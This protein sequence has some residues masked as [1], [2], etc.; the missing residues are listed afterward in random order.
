MRSITLALSILA[1]LA[2]ALPAT[3][4]P[5]LN[6]PC[7]NPNDLPVVTTADGVTTDVDTPIGLPLLDVQTVSGGSYLVDLAGVE[8][9][10][11]KTV[12]VTLSWT[13]GILDDLTDYDM[14]VNGVTYNASDTRETATLSMGHCKTIN[15]EEIYDVHRDPGRQL[16]PGPGHLLLPLLGRV[17]PGTGLTT[18]AGR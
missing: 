5:V 18:R 10:V 9:N 16:D 2:V 11:K 14:I 7:A 6:A 4:D 1:L 8:E 12:T 15:V 13:N 3:A 17:L